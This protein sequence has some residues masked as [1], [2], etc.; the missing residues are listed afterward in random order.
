MPKLLTKKKLRELI[1][2][3]VCVTYSEPH[4]DH[5]VIIAQLIEADETGIAVQMDVG[6]KVI[7]IEKIKDISWKNIRFVSPKE[8]FDKQDDNE[9]N[10]QMDSINTQIINKIKSLK[11]Y[12][13]STR[14]ARFTKNGCFKKEQISQK[15]FEFEVF[16]W[17]KKRSS[18]IELC[19]LALLNNT[20][21]LAVYQKRFLLFKKD[22]SIVFDSD[23]RDINDVIAFIFDQNDQIKKKRNMSL[24]G[25]AEDLL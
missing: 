10:L 6:P 22:F 25:L 13:L 20:L 2:Q 11:T 9:L 7:T 19:P 4:N 23:H 1:G 8:Y 18:F 24:R 14:K 12:Y 17:I 21:L 15:K 5:I 16:Q 3:D